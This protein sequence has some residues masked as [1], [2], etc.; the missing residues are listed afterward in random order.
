[1]YKIYYWVKIKF[2]YLI[3]FHVYKNKLQLIKMIGQQ[4]CKDLLVCNVLQ[5][6]NKF[7]I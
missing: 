6:Y 2:L 7:H 1:M 5:V 4:I 3:N